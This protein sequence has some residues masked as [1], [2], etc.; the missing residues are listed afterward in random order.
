MILAHCNLFLPGST[1][2]PASASRGLA[3]LPSLE[4]NGAVTPHCSLDIQGSNDLPSLASLVAGKLGQHRRFPYV[5]QS[6]LEL[7][8][9]RD[10]PTSTSQSADITGMSHCSWPNFLFSIS[11]GDAAKNSKFIRSF[12]RATQRV[13]IIIIIPIIIIIII[14]TEFHSC[15]SDWS[16]MAPSWL[17]T[18]SASGFKQFSCLSLPSSWDYRHAAPSLANFEFLVETGFLHVSQAGLELP[19]SGDL[20]ALASQSA[21]ITGMSHGARPHHYF[22]LTG[23]SDSPATASRVAGTRGVCYHAQL[24]FLLLVETG[25]HYV[26][27]DGLDLLSS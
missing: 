21:G 16:A 9:S 8:R 23:L 1:D 7:L 19:T 24:I 14:E 6:G 26:G 10:L 13:C 22:Y 25:F 18:T 20:P 3:L 27:K 2:S 17:T 12:N 4:Y 11:R 5:A 15:C